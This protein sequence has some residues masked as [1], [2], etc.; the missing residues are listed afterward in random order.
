MCNSIDGHGEDY[1]KGNKPVTKRQVLY[2]LM[3]IINW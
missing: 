3:N 1:A 2:D